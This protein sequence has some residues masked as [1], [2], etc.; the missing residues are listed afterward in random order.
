MKE[1]FLAVSSL[2]ACLLAPDGFDDVAHVSFDAKCAPADIANIIK[3]GLD[4]NFKG[5]KLVLAANYKQTIIRITNRELSRKRWLFSK[6]ISDGDAWDI[7]KS[8]FPI[9]PNINE[10][11][12]LFDISLFEGKK[13]VCLG[14]PITLC[15][16][17]AEI[18]KE[19]TGSFHK[20]SRIETIEHLLFVKHCR[21]SGLAPQAGHAADKEHNKVLV[22]PQDG[23]LR[24]L[25]VQDGLPENAFFISNHP[26]RRE[27]EFECILDGIG[28]RGEICISSFIPF[29]AE[30]CLEWVSK[31]I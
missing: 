19:L 25:V 14:L 30:F 28:E 17:L 6:K 11:T 9:G 3:E 22:F 15:E 8:V 21:G 26:N 2:G 18:G 4:Y 29:G 20:I 10:D 16:F 13:Y 7:I 5:K 24:V 27:A 1:I 12:H 31:Y 23:G